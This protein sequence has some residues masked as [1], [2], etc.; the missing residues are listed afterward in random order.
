M[1]KAAE[2]ASGSSQVEPVAV[3]QAARIL[4]AVHSGTELVTELPEKTGLEPAQVLSLV[5]KMAD[6]GLIAV[7]QKGGGELHVRVTDA[8]HEALT[9]A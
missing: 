9:A 8:T 1:T 2:G 7:E 6:S 4:A 5:G 3:D